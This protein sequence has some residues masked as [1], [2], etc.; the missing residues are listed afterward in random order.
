[1]SLIKAEQPSDTFDVIIIGMGPA[2]EVAASRLAQ[3]GKRLAVIEAELIGGECAYWACMPS[4][5]LLRATEVLAQTEHT[6]GVSPARPEWPEL[7][8]ARDSLV[9][10]LDDSAQA[11]GYAERG[12]TVVRGRAR[13]NGPGQVIVGERVLHAEQIIVATGS[14]SARPAIEGLDSV[15]VW[16][17]REATNLTDIPA[18]AVI[19]GGGAAGIELATFLGRMGTQVTVVQS[20][21]R[22]LG[23][24]DPRV[25]ELAAE[26]LTRAG[27][28][29]ITGTRVV[30]A[31]KQGSGAVV[32][33][34][35]GAEI[36]TDVLILAA[37][38]TPNTAGLNLESAGVRLDE[39]G[40]IEVDDSCLA[41]PGVWAIGDVNAILPLTHVG[42]YQGRIVA[43]TILGQPRRARYEGIPRAVFADPEIAATGLTLE[44]ARARGRRLLTVELDLAAS[45]A[46]PWTY[47]TDPVGR[48]AL[49]ADADDDVLLGAWAIGPMASEW[50][51]QA[52]AAIRGRTPLNEIRDSVAQFPSYSEA[53]LAAVERLQP[54][55]S[56]A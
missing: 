10:H 32:T 6:A 37:G 40:A 29:V 47:E 25:G 24:E 19:V 23:R 35:D 4:K 13:L 52:A 43:D 27:I 22:L 46:R 26:A 14:S 50:I 31:A 12:V 16:T 56:A 1:M 55:A 21:A 2:G 11:D 53:Y 48:L 8:A 44:Q 7:R 38:R 51:H 17:N 18:R 39:H 49:I 33:L 15:T 20:G 9:R 41:A 28:T 34:T 30:R 45:L 5:I 3:G 36:S 54:D 42:K